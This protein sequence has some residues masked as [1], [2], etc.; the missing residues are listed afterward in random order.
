MQFG[1]VN[2]TLDIAMEAILTYV[3][4]VLE[5]IAFVLS[6][7]GNLIICYVLV[8]KTNLPPGRAG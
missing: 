7:F 6:V 8:Y 4:L 2:S 5:T 1:S 3:Y